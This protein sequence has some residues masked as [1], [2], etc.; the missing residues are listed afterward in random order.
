[1]HWTILRPS[2]M[3]MEL[4]KSLNSPSYERLASGDQT[5]LIPTAGTIKD[6]LTFCSKRRTTL[7]PHAALYDELKDEAL[8]F[9]QV[10]LR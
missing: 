2:A 3:K 10:S 8:E 5:H 9:R 6:R 7:L 1:M 4:L